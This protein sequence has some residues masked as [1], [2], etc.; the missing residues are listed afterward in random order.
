MNTRAA[1]LVL[2]VFAIAL[3]QTVRSACAAPAT[4]EWRALSAT[5]NDQS[6]KAVLFELPRALA[7]DRD[8]NIYV[9]NEKGVKALQKI[10][11]DGTITTVLDRQ[12]KNIR[13]QGYVDLS[14]AVD[15]MGSVLIGVGGRGTIER[16]GTDGALTILA[17]VPGKPGLVD[18]AKTAGFFRKPKAVAVDR[19]GAIYVADSR[20]IRKLDIDGSLLTLAGKPSADVYARDGR[21]AHAAFGSPNGIALDASGNLYVADGGIRRDGEKTVAFGL[22]R[23]VDPK[24]IVTTLA[25][26]LDADGSHIDG[27]GHDAGFD[28]VAAITIDSADNNLFVTESYGSVRKIDPAGT[29]TSIVDHLRRYDEPADRDG[30]NPIFGQLT[31]TAVGRDR[32]IYVVDSG[33]NKLHKIDD[34]GFVKTLCTRAAPGP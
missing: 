11:T 1:N 26:S 2:I 32:E 24:G 30:A 3:C 21:G 8:G 31:G 28:V 4:L 13:G 20:T 33:A 15:Q 16:L 12:A 7:I 19:T 22:I 14:L 6:C 18:G 10:S 27:T 25:G 9:G 29:V 5:P 17:G 23:K 34:S